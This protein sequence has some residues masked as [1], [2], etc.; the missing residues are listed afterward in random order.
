MTERT[1]KRLADGFEPT[2]RD[3][4]WTRRARVNLICESED[5]AVLL[6]HE[7]GKRGWKTQVST[8]LAGADP[9]PGSAVTVTGPS[10]RVVHVRMGMP[11]GR[12]IS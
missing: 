5:E 7:L 10:S 2:L 1:A 4:R 11:K 12:S 8:V 9:H 3:K 6:A